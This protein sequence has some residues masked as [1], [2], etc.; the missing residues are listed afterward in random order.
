MFKKFGLMLGIFV[1]YFLVAS[2]NLNVFAGADACLVSNERELKGAIGAVGD[3]RYIKMTSDIHVR[4]NLYLDKP[5]MLDLGGHTLYLNDMDSSIVVGNRELFKVKEYIYGIKGELSVSSVAIGVASDMFYRFLNKTYK[6]YD[7]IEVVIEN[8]TVRHADG[9]KGKDGTSNAWL[10][11]N[12]FKGK[13][14]SEVFKII[15]G[16]LELR[17]VCAYGGNGGDG[18]NGSYQKLI[19]IPW[20]TGDGGNG[21][22]GG[23]GGN[24]INLTR[25]KCKVSLQGDTMLIPGE[26]GKGGQKGKNN[27]GYWIYSG[28]EGRD[29]KNGKSGDDIERSW[30]WWRWLF[31]ATYISCDER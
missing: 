28:F 1:V 10:S 16:S 22:R 26:G 31:G 20:G 24:V 6:C 3:Y 13:T 8:G 25:K 29:G 12:G 30:R 7:G 9:L 11:H 4:G 17:D 5:V 21:G 23:N 15:S 2:C 14:P 19:H 18:G 27:Y